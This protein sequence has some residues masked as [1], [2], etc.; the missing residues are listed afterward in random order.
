MWSPIDIFYIGWFCNFSP[1]QDARLNL[2]KVIEAKENK[3]I[4]QSVGLR[5]D[6]ESR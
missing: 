3:S 5:N 6:L 2:A 1:C 4:A